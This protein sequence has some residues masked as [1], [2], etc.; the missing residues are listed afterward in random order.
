MTKAPAVTPVQG[1]IA[2]CTRFSQITILLKRPSCEKTWKAEQLQ[3]LKTF[4]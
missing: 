3:G 2:I 1:A 4:H